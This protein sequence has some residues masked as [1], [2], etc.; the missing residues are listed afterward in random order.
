MKKTD[1]ILRA[2]EFNRLKLEQLRREVNIGPEEI[3]LGLQMRYEK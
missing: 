3:K 2:D 1:I